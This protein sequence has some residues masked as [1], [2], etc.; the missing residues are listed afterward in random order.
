MSKEPKQ[1]HVLIY[2]VSIIH[3]VGAGV[4]IGLLH[5]LFHLPAIA[6]VSLLILCF[7]VLPPIVQVVDGDEKDEQ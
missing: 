4:T 3:W 1:K 2:L 6:V 5:S 7:L